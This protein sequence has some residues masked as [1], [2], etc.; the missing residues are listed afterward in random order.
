MESRTNRFNESLDSLTGTALGGI[1]LATVV[2]A[3]FVAVFAASGC[4]GDAG[5]SSSKDVLADAGAGASDAA[6]DPAPTSTSARPSGSSGENGGVGAGSRDAGDTGGGASGGGDGPGAEG[7]GATVTGS[8][9]RA[10]SDYSRCDRD[11]DCPVGYG[12][13]VREV[14]LNSSGA[15]GKTAVAVSDIF[16]EVDTGGVCSRVCTNEPSACSELSVRDQRGDAVPYTCQLVVVGE[17]PYVGGEFPFE[18]DEEAMSAGIAF[19]AICRPPF[20]LHENVEDS[21][22]KECSSNGECGAGLCYE[23]NTRALGSAADRGVCLAPCEEDAECPGGFTCE[24]LTD[25]GEELGS[26]CAPLLE[27]CGACLDRDADG[28]GVGQCGDRGTLSTPVDCDDSNPA[29]YFDVDDPAHAFPDS[30]GEQDY[31]CNGRSDAAEQLEEPTIYGAEHCG[32]CGNACAGA[33]ENGDAECL[34]TDLGGVCGARCE[35]GW[36]DCTDEPGCETPVDDPSR[37]YFPDRDGDGFGDGSAP[38]QFACGGQ[39]PQGS[40]QDASDCDDDSADVYPGAPE[41]CDG[42]D[43]DCNGEFDE[44]LA[45]DGEPWYL[46]ADGDGFGDPEEFTMACQQPEGYVGSP[47][48]CVD[49]DEL[50]NPSAPDDDC[51]GVDDDC[52]EQTDEDYLAEIECDGDNSAS[53][54]MCVD[55]ELVCE[56][57]PSEEFDVPGDGLDSDCDGFDADVGAVIFAAP[58]DDPECSGDQGTTPDNPCRQLQAALDRAAS[59]GKSVVASVGTYVTEVAIELRSGVS[60]YGGFDF[61]TGRLASG[62]ET[63]VQRVGAGHRVV[64]VGLD[65]HSA[66]TLSEVVL[67]ALT[68]DEPGAG[69]YGL[70][71]DGCTG[72]TL[73]DVLVTLEAA[74]DGAVGSAGR[75]GNFGSNG[76]NRSGNNTGGA[77]GANYV[78]G[79]NGGSA[80]ECWSSAHTDGQGPNGGKS[81]GQAGGDGGGSTSPGVG[82]SGFVWI[83]WQTDL[84]LWTS[85]AGSSGSAG[86]P[87]SGGAGG[88]GF[89]EAKYII[90]YVG[91]DWGGGG[92]GGGGGEQGFGGGGGGGG[93]SSIGMQLRDSAGLAL[94]STEIRVGGAGRGG[95]GGVGGDGGNGGARGLG[96]GGGK[97]GGAGGKG[98]GGSGGGGGVGG[99]VV[100]LLLDPITRASLDMTG[101]RRGT[102]THVAG[103]GGLG[104]MGGNATTGNSGVEGLPGAAGIACDVAEVEST[105]DAA[106]VA[107]LDSAEPELEAL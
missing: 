12:D 67:E 19:G 89:H 28:Y 72:L 9:A 5:T 46:D 100:N 4:N 106:C 13:C 29:A 78:R 73:R 81:S 64:V 70:L 66:T 93:G 94:L 38:S 68:P 54:Y 26:F 42:R 65:I 77:G 8:N 32:A 7:G 79:G 10:L 43:N 53:V 71:C 62:G 1:S 96:G 101:V 91:C 3:A 85:S 87:G 80:D 92:G 36:A 41:L 75:A 74:A 14:S 47:G 56:C 103:A 102:T 76:G 59:E 95:T 58:G 49:D 69:T 99:S 82:G 52:D 18:V 105:G 60:L 83:P 50:I 39:A 23:L 63:V 55:G 98:G 107:V 20:Q 84:Q 30:C 51:N 44:G 25:R 22:C 31:N 57:V 15:A 45:E 11:S 40:V 37:L 104:G 17:S 97:H 35:T 24:S 16:P 61:A 2:A 88:D 90:F 48:D 33:V 86:L 27:T 21:F 6:T 34:V